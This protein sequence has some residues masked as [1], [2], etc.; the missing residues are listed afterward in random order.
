M[1]PANVQNADFIVDDGEDGSVG[2]AVSRSKEDLS[3]LLFNSI[4]LRGESTAAWIF[5]E[6]LPGRVKSIQPADGSVWRTFREP[7]SDVCQLR[8]GTA[9]QDDVERHD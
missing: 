8:F 7:D 6:R 4:V 9:E 3:N 5:G 1:G 2:L